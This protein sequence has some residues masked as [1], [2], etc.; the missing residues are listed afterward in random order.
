M[1]ESSEYKVELDAFSGP[2]DLLLYLIRRDE[3]DIWN[4]PV[5]RITQQYLKYIEMMGELNIN[6]AGEF[7][8][9]A[10]TLIE[11]K[12]RMLAPEPAPAEDEEQ[13]DP[14]ME[15]VRQLMEYRRFKEAAAALT[16]RA[17]HQSQRFAR[18]GE[19]PASEDADKTAAPAGVN[20]WALF[21]AFSKVLQQTGARG[22]HRLI[23]DVIPQEQIQKGL[24]ER[25]RAEGRTNF[26]SLFQGEA[27]RVRMIGMFLALLELVKQ[28][29]LRIEQDET[30][31]DIYITYVPPEERSFA[32]AAEDTNEAAEPGVQQEEVEDDAVPYDGEWPEEEVSLPDV[33]DVGD[34]AG[35]GGPESASPDG[36]AEVPPT[37]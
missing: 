15:L 10:A 4:I 35:T 7:V 34:D 29:A 12:S 8:V 32:D 24:E 5:A 31:G 18:F 23:L 17:D 13:D 21:D 16:E 37:G 20:I 26:F 6:V 11:I 30:F 28:Q 22:D 25:L 2:L 14:R 19:R 1:S 27:S 33:P 9:M 3:V 36:D